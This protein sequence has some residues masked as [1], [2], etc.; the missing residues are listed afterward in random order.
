MMTIKLINLN[1]EIIII[2]MMIR[3][4]IMINYYLQ[5]IRNNFHYK[6]KIRGTR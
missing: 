1:K 6:S 3:E 4:K 5:Q 2:L